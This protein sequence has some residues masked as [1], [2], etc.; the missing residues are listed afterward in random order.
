M[1]AASDLGF[2]AIDHF[3]IIQGVA[4]ETTACN[5]CTCEPQFGSGAGFGVSPVDPW[6]GCEVR[7]K[8]N[9]EEPALTC[10]G[11]RR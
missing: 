2:L 3:D 6:I 11:D 8:R 4:D 9:I 10:I 1:T 7:I 5:G